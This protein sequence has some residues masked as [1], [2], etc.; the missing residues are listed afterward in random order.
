ML[1]LSAMVKLYVRS[2]LK[3]KILIQKKGTAHLLEKSKLSCCILLR[4]LKFS[5]NDHGI[6]T[7]LLVIWVI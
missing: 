4:H 7:L 3:K 1:P 5:L 6:I 2:Y